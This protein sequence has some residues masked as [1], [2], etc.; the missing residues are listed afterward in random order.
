[1]INTTLTTLDLYSV[2]KTEKMQKINNDELNDNQAAILE[3][4]EQ[5]N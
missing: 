1:M 3:W 2:T 4:K 5:K